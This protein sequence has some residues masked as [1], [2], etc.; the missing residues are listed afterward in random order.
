MVAKMKAVCYLSAGS[1]KI[2]WPTAI[3]K[4]RM[5]NHDFGG[6]GRP[7]GARTRPGWKS[8]N[9]SAKKAKKKPANGRRVHINKYTE[10][11][12]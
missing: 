6:R 10:S 4:R 1:V 11:R 2:L 5:A 12:K 3:R 8:F 7:H 9:G